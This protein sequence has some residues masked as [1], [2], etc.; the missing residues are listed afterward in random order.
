MV[1]WISFGVVLGLRKN[2]QFTVPFRGFSAQS[3]AD[4]FLRCAGR[5]HCNLWWRLSRREKIILWKVLLM[6]HWLVNKRKKKKQISFLPTKQEPR[7]LAAV[8]DAVWCYEMEI[9]CRSANRKRQCY[10]RCPQ[11]KMDA[12]FIRFVYLIHLAPTGASKGVVH[13]IAGYRF[14]PPILFVNT[15]LYKLA[16]YITSVP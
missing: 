15:F 9:P 12:V 2:R 7:F 5:I 6:T 8:E 16:I 11:H 3:I 1:P 4:R 13:S 10:K 14:G